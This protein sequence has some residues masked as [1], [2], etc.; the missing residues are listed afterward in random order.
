MPTIVLVIGEGTSVADVAILADVNHLP[1]NAARVFFENQVDFFYLD[2][3][4]LLN[5]AT[6]SNDCIQIASMKY[7]LLIVDDFEKITS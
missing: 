1:W 3:D 2:M 5:S 4:T 6:V 7:S